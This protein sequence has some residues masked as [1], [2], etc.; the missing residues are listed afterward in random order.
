MA[1]IR[2]TIQ[3]A[4]EDEFYQYYLEIDASNYHIYAAEWTPRYIDF[5]ADNV[6]IRQIQQSPSYPMQFMLGIYE[7]PEQLERGSQMNSW[8]KTFEVDYIRSYQPV[9]GYR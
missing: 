9:N 8:P 7:L 3:P 2:S 5:F 1:Y 4:I 6:K